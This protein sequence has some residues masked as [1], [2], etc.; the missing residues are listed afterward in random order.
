MW[1][2]HKEKRLIKTCKKIKEQQAKK[3]AAIINDIKYKVCM[4]IQLFPIE[5]YNIFLVIC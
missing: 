5:K 4:N 3:S 2:F 1:C